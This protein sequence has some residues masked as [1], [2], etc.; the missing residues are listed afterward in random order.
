[1]KDV[2]KFLQK[3][4]VQYLATIGCDGKAK[5][6]PFMFSMESEGKLWFCTNTEKEVYRE[7]IKNPY[8]ELCVSDPSNV[9]LRLSGKA[10]FENNRDVKENGM[11]IPLVKSIYQN[12]DNPIFTVFYLEEARAVIMDFSGNPPRHY[13]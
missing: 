12:A 3:N 11:Q 6:R 8:L 7:L 4:P 5:C 10:V 13:K 1:M 2:V 9:W